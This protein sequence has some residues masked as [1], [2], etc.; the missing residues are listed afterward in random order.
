M[1]YTKF[2]DEL[3]KS[4]AEFINLFGFDNNHIVRADINGTRLPDFP[5]CL[6]TIGRSKQLA[7]NTH[8]NEYDI[9]TD[10]L[11]EKISTSR[12][13]LVH[14]D[15][16]GDNSSDVATAVTQLFRD[17]KGINIFKNSG[18]VPLYVEDAQRLPY[19]DQTSTIYNRHQTV[20][21][22]NHHPA[23]KFNEDY[24]EKVDLITERANNVS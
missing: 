12:E 7:T 24:F 15:F 8:Y 20:L 11:V 4:C 19:I 16:Y 3:Y 18:F 1:E 5:F 22:F 23:L 21:H 13:V 6:I 17:E 2:Y 10:T 9:N 14:L